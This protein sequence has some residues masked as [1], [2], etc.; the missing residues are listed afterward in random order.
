M[1][2]ELVV[3]GC[4]YVIYARTLDLVGVVSML[5]MKGGML[6]ESPLSGKSGLESLRGRDP[7]GKIVGDEERI[8]RCRDRVLGFHEEQ[9]QMHLMSEFLTIKQGSYLVRG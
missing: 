2:Y 7:D 1:F 6:G 3:H 8:S 4:R 5:L 9:I